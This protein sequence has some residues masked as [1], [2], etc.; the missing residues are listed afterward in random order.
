MVMKAMR[1]NMKVLLWVTAIIFIGGTF[2]G[3]GSYYFSKRGAEYDTDLVAQINDKKI[4]RAQFEQTYENQL[5]TYQSVYNMNIT[6]EMKPMI[7]K[8][9]LE[10]MIQVELMLAEIKRQGI[11][12]SDQE[13]ANKVR[14]IPYF[15]KNGK[16]SQEQ[17]FELLKYQNKTPETFENEVRNSIKADKITRLITSSIK[18]TTAEMMDEYNRRKYNPKEEKDSFRARRLMIADSLTRQ[19]QNLYYQD[20]ASSLKN[21]AVIVNNLAKIDQLPK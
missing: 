21:K 14:G 11:E 3:L 2:M 12:A 8:S 4:D 13:V 7:R 15:Q 19:N 9:V 20:W 17:Y 1:K 10:G 16:F 18:L 6:D 5:Q